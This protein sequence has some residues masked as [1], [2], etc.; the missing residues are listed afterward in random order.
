VFEQPAGGDDVACDLL[1]FGCEFECRGDGG[2]CRLPCDGVGRGLPGP[3][4]G[5]GGAGTA[6][7]RVLFLTLA[8]VPGAQPIG[9]RCGR[10]VEAVG[11]LRRRIRF[12]FGSPVGLRTGHRVVPLAVG[13]GG[14]GVLFGDT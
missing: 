10:A 7:T 5:C 1:A 13:A 2:G 11:A 4:V 12:R 9:T 14:A 3:V 8:A 6:A